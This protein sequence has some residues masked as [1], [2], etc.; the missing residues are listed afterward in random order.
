M[1]MFTNAIPFSLLAWGQQYVTSSFAGITMAVVP[2]LV[3]R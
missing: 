2:L 3:H 1:G